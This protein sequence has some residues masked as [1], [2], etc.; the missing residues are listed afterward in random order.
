MSNNKHLLMLSLELEMMRKR[1]ISA[2]LKPRAF[3]VR[4]IKQQHQHQMEQQDDG[5]E[6]DEDEEDL[7][8][9]EDDDEGEYNEEEEVRRRGAEAAGR[10]IQRPASSPPRMGREHAHASPTTTSAASSAGGFPAASEGMRTPE[11]R[12][13]TLLAGGSSLRY[14]VRLDAPGAGPGGANG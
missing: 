9:D 3:V 12:A 13:R 1:K 11:M 4:W 10:A 6:E 5:R 7:Y 8:E 14:E 2:P